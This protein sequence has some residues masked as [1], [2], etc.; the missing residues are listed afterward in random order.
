MIRR[1]TLLGSALAIAAVA[2]PFAARGAGKIPR[3]GFVTAQPAAGFAPFVEPFRSGLTD[4]GYV[5]GRSLLTEFRYGDD[6]LQRVP[7]L[8]A[9]LVRLPVDLLVV[10][11]AAV[12]VVAKLGLQL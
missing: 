11:G 2:R 10:Q 6:D 4:L 1:R 5:E 9:E 12:R 7:E 8:V 3:V